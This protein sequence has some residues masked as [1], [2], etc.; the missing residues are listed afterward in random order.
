MNF[1]LR[2]VIGEICLVYLDDIIVFSKTKEEHLLNLERIFDLLKE[3]NLKLGLSKCKF[4]CESVQYLGHV[5]SATW[6]MNA[7]I[8][9]CSQAKMKGFL[10]FGD[11]NCQIIED[12]SPPKAVVYTLLS[13]LPEVKRFP[14]Y[15]C[16]VWYA[17]RTLSTDFFGWHTHSQSKWPVVATPNK[18]K[19]GIQEMWESSDE[20][21]GSTE[22]YLRLV[23][24]HATIMDENHK[25]VDAKLQ[26]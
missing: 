18:K 25:T 1:V 6:A 10:N 2:S 21:S 15:M 22:I 14:G 8:C 13:H 23:S 11:E 4:M 20:S 19:E 24:F 12:P 17:H 16:S 7:T 3:A 26:N 5:I 9:D